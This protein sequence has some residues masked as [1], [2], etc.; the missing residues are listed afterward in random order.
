ME[1]KF[2]FECPECGQSIE[3][4][5]KP[6]RAT[7]ICPACAKDVP[8][9]G[10]G[11]NRTII[12]GILGGVA[13]LLAILFLFVFFKVQTQRAHER[14]VAA[15]RAAEAAVRQKKVKHLQAVEAEKRRWL[16]FTKLAERSVLKTEDDYCRAVSAL[17]KYVD[18]DPDEI[19]KIRVQLKRFRAED[20]KKV[21]KKL[22]AKAKILA[23]NNE[24]LK[25]AGVYQDYGG[26]FKADT[27]S[28]RIK[29][30]EIYF[31]KAEKSE[32]AKRALVKKAL[33]EKEAC[34]K[35]LA[36]GLIRRSAGKAIAKF[37]KS[38]YKKDFPEE[39]ELL[40]NLTNIS[41][42]VAD[43]FK[44]D[45]GKKISVSLKNGKV[46]LRIKKVEDCLIYAEYKKSKMLITEK[47]AIKDL[48]DSE[49]MKRLSAYN[50]A[51]AALAGGIKAVKK[52][53]FDLAE[54]YF[55]NTGSIS[56]LLLEN[57]AEYKAQHD[58]IEEKE[59]NSED[60]K[61]K[62]S[63]PLNFKKLRVT[64]KVTKGGKKN[65]NLGK[66]DEKLTARFSLSNTNAQ[67]VAGCVLTVFLI[68]ESLKNKKI[69]KFIK[70]IR[71]DIN[72][73]GRKNMQK[74]YSFLN[75]YNNGAEISTAGDQIRYIPKDGHKYYSWVYVI[76]DSSGEI[77]IV[78]FKHKKFEKYSIKIVQAGKAEFSDE[79]QVFAL[80]PEKVE[81][82]KK[83]P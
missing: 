17:E 23:V 6:D 73:D 32:A 3:L 22:D 54:K 58:A 75:S 61:T 13:I 49:V 4:E 36:S 79:G 80:P 60:H 5:K 65:L 27:E 14:R 74:K 41:G 63:G 51:T 21:M 82:K 37:N 66:I 11:I 76:K 44:K 45:I 67:P 50:E 77:K 34:I 38:K 43:S 78:K 42:I 19:L 53:K 59:E 12:V 52:R 24:F 35:E 48:N 2:N 1:A 57:L 83:Q 15:K 62:D 30:A 71:E 8:L 55:R 56:G 28:A 81:K 29:A 20:S 47:Y 70:E 72:L 16:T 7:V 25:A 31:S 39:S 18:G 69:Y 68:G 40:D 46:N 9:P 26:D 33:A 10:K 64:M